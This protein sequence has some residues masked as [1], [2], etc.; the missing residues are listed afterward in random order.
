MS[1]KVLSIY[2]IGREEVHMTQDYAAEMLGVSPRQLARYENLEVIPSCEMV[3]KMVK[4]YDAKWLGYTYL[5][6]YNNVGKMILPEVTFQDV[7][8]GTLRFFKDHTDI[9][10]LKSEMIDIVCDGIIDEH[11]QEDWENIH[12]K[13]IRELVAA[14]LSLL[15]LKEDGNKKGLSAATEKA[16]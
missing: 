16:S 2:K 5:K 7:G 10:E 14:G 11:E 4:L 12:K 9:E 3:A 6:E 1:D 8:L 15:L 13:E